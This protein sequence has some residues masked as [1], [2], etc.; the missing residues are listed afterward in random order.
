MPPIDRMRSPESSSNLLLAIIR[1]QQLATWLHGRVNNAALPSSLR[2]HT[3][4][5]ILQ[6]AEDIVDG[7]LVLLSSRLPGPA[8]SLA[9]PML[10]GYVRGYWLRR[11]ATD[12]QIAEFRRGKCPNFPAL[13]KAIP[14]DLASGGAWIHANVRSNLPSFHDLT[15]GGSEHVKR[16]DGA[17]YIEPSYPETELRSLVELGIEVRLR[18]AFELLAAWNDEE[19]LAQL[20]AHVAEYRSQR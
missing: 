14:D 15:H 13:L 9:R 2:M 10:E 3:A 8:L 5:A 12:D 19:G 18:I 16:R 1:A 6:L 17:E 20:D 4:L 11:F 7:I